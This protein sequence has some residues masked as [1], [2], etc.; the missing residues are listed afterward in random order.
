[1]SNTPVKVSYFSDVL[2]VW[3]YADQ[4]RL[5]EVRQQFGERIEIEEHFITLFGCTKT[6]IGEGW[7]PKGGY[8]GFSQHVCNVGEKFDH[9]TINPDVWTICRPNTSAMA[10]LL[11]KA[12]QIYLIKKDQDN[13][14]VE[15]LAKAIRHAFFVDAKDIS[16][17]P[18]LLTIAEQ[19]KLPVDQLQGFIEDG[20]AMSALMKDM[21]LKEQYKLEGSPS[22]VLNEGRQKL[23]GNI[24]YRVI[25]A[26]IQELLERPMECASWC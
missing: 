12:L 22:Y 6:R 20:S 3:A 5:D 19:L 15:Q 24:G 23:Y 16:Q 25:E 7:E 17:L 13:Q 8:D 1:M 2:C 18:V 9:L 10:H 11:L 21:Q 26:N 4:I 14:Q